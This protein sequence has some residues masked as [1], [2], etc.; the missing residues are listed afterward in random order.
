MALSHLMWCSLVSLP[1]LMVSIDGN[2]VVGAS[3]FVKDQC[4]GDKREG[5][6]I[7]RLNA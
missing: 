4:G 5:G 2:K 6:D 7:T 3:F 1:M